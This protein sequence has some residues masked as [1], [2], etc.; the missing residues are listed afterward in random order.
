MCER[1][2]TTW[3]SFGTRLDSVPLW[4]QG[5]KCPL[6]AHGMTRFLRDLLGQCSPQRSGLPPQVIVYLC[7]VLF[8]TLFSVS[9]LNRETHHYS[10]LGLV[11]LHLPSLTLTNRSPCMTPTWIFLSESCVRKD[12]YIFQVQKPVEPFWVP[13]C[14]RLNRIIVV[15]VDQSEIKRRFRH[16]T[17]HI[18]T[19]MFQ[20]LIKWLG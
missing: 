1:L 2:N 10:C 16:I 8:L 4:H 12:N 14:Q 11:C 9:V 17:C 6:L 18:I 3:A 5:L 7:L 13:A 19:F 20:H 15:L